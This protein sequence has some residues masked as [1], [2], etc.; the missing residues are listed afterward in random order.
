M[1]ILIIRPGAI[2]DALLTFPIIQA[3]KVGYQHAHVTLVSNP[4]VLPLARAW[5]VADEV[6]DYGDAQW[7]DLF[8]MAGIRSPA[9]LRVLQWTT[10]AICWLRDT[11]VVKRNLLAADIQQVIVAPGRP[12]EGMHMHIVEY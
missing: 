10:M 4:A 5:H 3:L 1:H 9:V 12:P 2:G 11:D 6:A 8:S 7:S